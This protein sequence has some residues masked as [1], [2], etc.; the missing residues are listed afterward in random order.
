MFGLAAGVLVAAGWFVVVVL[1]TSRQSY[2]ML[3]VDL[4]VAY[5]V[6]LGLHRA[7]RTAAL[8]AA[9]VTLVVLLPATYWVERYLVVKWFSD[10]GDELHVPIVPY[11]DWVVEVLGHA[12][13]ESV[14]VAVFGLLAVAVAVFFGFQGFEHHLGRG[15]AEIDTPADRQQA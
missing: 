14:G 3:V 11:L 5:G 9:A 10:N 1:T 12:V 15:G 2:L 7:S 8:I 6:H 4:A 13:G